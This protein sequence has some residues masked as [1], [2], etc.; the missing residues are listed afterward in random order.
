MQ[1]HTCQGGLPGPSPHREVLVQQLISALDDL[2]PETRREALVQLLA[3]APPL[4]TS[5]PPAQRGLNLHCHTIY[6]YNGYGYA[7]AS[8]AWLARTQGW[9]AL[10]TVDFDVLDGVDETL[11]AC[12][13]AG[14]RGA[15]GLETRAYLADR[16][17]LTYNSPGE[18]GV[19]YYVGMGFCSSQPPQAARPI[20][21]DLRARA[22]ARNR[23]MVALLND[24]LSPVTVAYDKDVVPLT[25]SGNATER[26][27]LIAYD[28]AARRRFPERTKLVAYWADKLDMPPDRVEA[29][30]GDAPHPH[31][32][33]RAKLMK[34]GGVGYMAPGPDTFPALG[35]VIAAIAACDALP[36]YAFLDGQSDGEAEMAN[37][38]EDLVS[39]GTLGLVAIPDRN[40]NTSDAEKQHQLV[41]KFHATLDLAQRMGLP[42]FIGTEMN[43]PGQLLLDDLSVPALAPYAQQF[44]EGAD[45]IHAHTV[46]EG[47]C[48]AGYT[49]PWARA[50]LPERRQR[51]AFYA[52]L[53]SLLEP[54]ARNQWPLTGDLVASGPEAILA[55]LR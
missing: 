47:L 12:Q 48:G 40:W 20:L 42:V 2:A 15:A 45:L 22:E 23:E 51:A 30:L 43:K 14:L 49:S 34:Q 4:D 5:R 39:R 1:G 44:V 54:Q 52:Q 26:H 17:E 29:F 7:P 41:A 19:M 21:D 10:G 50:W 53:G 36:C 16:P 11:W 8:L 31:D 24:Y 9:Y 46:L 6:S 32:A 3:V 35:T 13:Q 38:L 33:I 27:L 55:S 37:L 25:P 18:P 28:A